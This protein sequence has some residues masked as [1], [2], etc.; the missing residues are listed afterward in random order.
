MATTAAE[1]LQALQG[2]WEQVGLEVDGVSNPPDAH[3]LP[4]AL[5]TFTENQFEVRASDGEL[6][7]AG[8]VALDPSFTPKQ[9]DCLDSMGADE[10]KRLPGIYGLEGDTFVFI[11]ANEG[12]PRPQVF[13]T[14]PG[15]TLRTFVRWSRRS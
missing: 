12:D 3:S 15:Q 2:I 6:L 4:G 13:R 11:L 10:G 7:L 1:D 8:S 9:F 14:G 5:T